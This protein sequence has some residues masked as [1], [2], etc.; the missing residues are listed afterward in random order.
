MDL[1]A[2]SL[3]SYISFCSEGLSTSLLLSRILCLPGYPLNSL[4]LCHSNHQI[5][6]LPQLI[7]KSNRTHKQCPYFFTRRTA[8]FFLSSC[9]KG[10]D[11]KGLGG[12]SGIR[13][14][15]LTAESP[16]LPDSAAVYQEDRSSE[17]TLHHTPPKAD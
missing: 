9:R 5:I 6:V 17:S 14:L 8:R 1:R 10:S 12:V 11:N 7:V 15:I 16:T 4:C 13:T 2:D 3:G